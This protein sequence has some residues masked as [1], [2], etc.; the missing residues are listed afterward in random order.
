M[1]YAPLIACQECDLL[2]QETSLQAGAAAHCKRCGTELYRQRADSLDRSLACALAAGGFFVVANTFPIVR[3]QI[4]T[5][6]THSTLFGAVP[7][8]SAQGMGVVAGLV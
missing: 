1:R 2:Q 3:L 5:E 4:Q 6:P 7:A 8:L